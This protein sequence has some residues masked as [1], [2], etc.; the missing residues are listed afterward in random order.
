[1][2]IAEGI[3]SPAQCGVWYA[4][5]APFVVWGAVEVVKEVKRHPENRLLLAT[6]GA[7][8]FV[9]SAIKLPSVSGSS[10]H[11]TG[12]GAGAVLF[13]P[14]VMAFL[15]MIVLIFQALL[16]AHGGISTLGANTFSMAI[17]G[18]AR[19][20]ELSRDGRTAAAIG[21]GLLA[22]VALLVTA[23]AIVVGVVVMASK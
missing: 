6:A 23:G 12:T 5:S 2:H 18:A 16:L 19:F 8:T 21:F 7:F 11:P 15:G 3:L 17:V 20:G 4:V 13:R 9:L 14:P 1:M 10:S 22:V